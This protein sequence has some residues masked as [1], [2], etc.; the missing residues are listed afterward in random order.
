M[1]R[2]LFEKTINI[3][4]QLRPWLTLETSALYTLL[5]R[6]QRHPPT[7]SQNYSYCLKGSF[8]PISSYTRMIYP[9]NFAIHLLKNWVL[10]DKLNIFG[11][12]SQ[13]YQTL[14][15]MTGPQDKHTT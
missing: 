5:T 6:C 14:Q 8:I 2:A 15:I 4:E 11:L 12:T 3:F 13:V 9:V 7:P 1:G 10:V